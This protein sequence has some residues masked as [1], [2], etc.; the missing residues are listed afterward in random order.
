MR[1][2]AGLLLAI[3]VS[4]ADLKL[5]APQTTGGRPLMEALNQRRTTRE[6]RREELPP[7]VLSNLLWAAFGIN[8]P[9]GKRTAPSA[10]NQQEIDLYVFTDAGVFLYDAKPHA[11]R[12]VFE[13][14]RREWAG[15]EFASAPV[16]IV[17]IAD[18]ARAGQSE[19]KDRLFYSAV[20]T[21]YISQNVYLFCASE[22]LA[23]VAHDAADKAAMAKRLNLRAGQFVILS[24]A[25]GYPR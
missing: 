20:N 6:F 18:F 21:G 4:A 24:Q 9:E 7:Q 3:A 22:G 23:T 16:T 19:A 13:G 11:L 5:P 14:D 15:K 8:R 17:F 2:F 12:R 10:W 1:L 25:V